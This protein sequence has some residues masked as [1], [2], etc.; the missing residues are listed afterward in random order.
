[1][2]VTKA[3]KEYI[4][5]YIS[6]SEMSLKYSQSNAT[7]ENDHSLISDSHNFT[8][9]MNQPLLAQNFEDTIGKAVFTLMGH[10]E[11]DLG[12]DY[13]ASKDLPAGLN[14]LD[15]I[16]LRNHSFEPVS[17]KEQEQSQV[18]KDNRQST[19]RFEPG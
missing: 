15:N 10:E 17:L 3:V 16:E 14:T 7:L 12:V 9:N 1:M 6:Y 18:M 11:V 13:F 5:M 2:P 4:T 8:T 19:P